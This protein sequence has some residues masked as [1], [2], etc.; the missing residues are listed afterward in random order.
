MGRRP[1]QAEKHRKV[2]DW[3]D[4]APDHVEPAEPAAVDSDMRPVAPTPPSSSAGPSS[5][6]TRK[7]Q[8][9]TAV[10]EIDPR[11]NDGNTDETEIVIEPQQQPDAAMEPHLRPADVPSGGSG[12]DVEM[13]AIDPGAHPSKPRPNSYKERRQGLTKEPVDP[14]FPNPSISK[15]NNRQ[16]S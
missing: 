5:S 8:S 4:A 12:N 2:D 15:H 3:L 10:E 6:V 9:D 13:S 14:V 1:Q 7:R 16:H 11:L